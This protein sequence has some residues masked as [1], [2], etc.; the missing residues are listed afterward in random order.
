[1]CKMF[2]CLFEVQHSI[3]T[4]CIIET[5]FHCIRLVTSL[6]W[7]SQNV[8]VIVKFRRDKS[9]WALNECRCDVEILRFTASVQTSFSLHSMNPCCQSAR[10]D[11]VYSR[12]VT[13]WPSFIESVLCHIPRSNTI[14][15]PQLICLFLNV[16]AVERDMYTFQIA[17]WRS[18]R[19]CHV[20]LC[21]LY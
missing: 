15:T 14:T 9:T 13:V 7:F 18:H 8:N 16:F 5:V 19:I 3:V 2:R 12:F 6:S 4:K 20:S 11:C 21:N 10:L 17:L 1:M